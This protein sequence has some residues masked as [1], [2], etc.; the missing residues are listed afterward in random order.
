MRGMDVFGVAGG[1]ALIVWVGGPNNRMLLPVYR[2]R[3]P[4][5]LR[6]DDILGVL[7]LT[8]RPAAICRCRGLLP[9]VVARGFRCCR[10]VGD[11]SPSS[12]S[13][14]RHTSLDFSQ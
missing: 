7:I 11:C 10:G 3:L 9:L 12:R 8:E 2:M 6:G 4:V 5:M 1:F 14:S 13:I